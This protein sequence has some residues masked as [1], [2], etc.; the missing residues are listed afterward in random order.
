MFFIYVYHK[1]MTINTLFC[2]NATFFPNTNWRHVQRK[3]VVYNVDISILGSP[4]QNEQKHT[5]HHDATDIQNKLFGVF[6]IILFDIYLLF[7]K[8]FI[9]KVLPPCVIKPFMIVSVHLIYGVF[10]DNVM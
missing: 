5:E 8:L 3:N 6:R 4:W 9:Q 2:F 7:L 10:N 1:I